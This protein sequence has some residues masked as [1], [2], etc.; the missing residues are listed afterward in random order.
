MEHIYIVFLFFLSLNINT[1]P[2]IQNR[3][4]TLF[5][6]PDTKTPTPSLSSTKNW[7]KC[8]GIDIGTSPTN[9][10]IV[11]NGRVSE[12]WALNSK[13]PYYVGPDDKFEFIYLENNLKDSNGKLQDLMQSK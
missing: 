4:R 1:L 9:F 6:S 10:D 3:D 2:L 12:S 8:N 5:S 13:I 7:E 11:S